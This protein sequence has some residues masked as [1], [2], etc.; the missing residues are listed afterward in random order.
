MSTPKPRTIV[1][2]SAVVAARLASILPNA[3]VSP[4]IYFDSKYAYPT[5]SW[6]K[7]SLLPSCRRWVT[8]D[9]D[10]EE[11]LRHHDCNKKAELLHTHAM[12]CLAQH[13][14]GDFESYTVHR[15]AY[16]IGGVVGKG[17]AINIVLTPKKHFF[18]EPQR[19]STVRLS[20]K[21]RESS[22]YVY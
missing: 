13:P 8:Q 2:S 11:W 4:V 18:V 9:L 19:F 21:E 1:V 22:W 10:L 7:R 14:G 6:V 5:E 17:H 20:K 3:K 12:G 16:N 15:L